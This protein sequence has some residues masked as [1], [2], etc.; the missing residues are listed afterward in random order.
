MKLYVNKPLNGLSGNPIYLGG[1]NVPPEERQ[2]CNLGHVCVEAL[3]AE[4]QG[5]QNEPGTKKLHRWQLA[6]GI[7]NKMKEETADM[8]FFDLPTE[9]LELIKTRIGKVYGADIVGP[10]Y[11]A[12]EI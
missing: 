1:K 7:T 10:A 6:K 11:T 2:Q 5:E 12:I 4:V 9:D 3:M 8:A